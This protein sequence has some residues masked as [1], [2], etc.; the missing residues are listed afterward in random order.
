MDSQE[1]PS[2]EPSFGK[3]PFDAGVE[4]NEDEDPQKFIQQ[5][6]G[7]LGQSLRQFTEE[8]G[9]PDFDLEKFAI[10]SVISAT[11]TSEMD[12][13][14]RNDIISK[15]EKSGNDT[16]DQEPQD[17]N[18]N[19]EPEMNNDGESIDGEE[20][21]FGESLNIRKNNR[22]FVKNNISSI[23]ESYENNININDI[24]DEV[25]SEPITKPI[26]KPDVKP[27]VVP[28]RRSKPFKVPTIRP[29]FAPNPKAID[30]NI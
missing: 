2:D 26:V 29:E 14:D 5:L 25:M 11:H 20:K 12:E 10:N 23:R 27:E 1:Q 17:D 13:E 19:T 30:N 18:Q 8:N 3:E 7:K 16:G 22:N 21:K 24:I 9:Q 4:A 6:S 28:S 15:I